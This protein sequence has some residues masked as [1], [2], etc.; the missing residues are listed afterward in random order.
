MIQIDYLPIVLTGIGIMVAIV[1]YTLTLRNA[2]KTR[3]AQLFMS[4]YETMRSQEFREQFNEIIRQEW[5]DFDDFWDKYGQDNNPEAW[6]KWQSVA[7][8]YHG[9]G[10]L[11]KKGLVE[12]SML[13]EL[14][15][16]NVYMAWVTMSPVLKGFIERSS[17]G[18]LRRRSRDEGRLSKMYSAWSGFEY[19]YDTLKKKEAEQL[20]GL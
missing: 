19:L 9:M 20:K 7:M 6:T 10:I 3:Q 11:V 1:Y 12:P 8:F 17:T 5:S 13:D 16:P 15:S 4:L 18:A 14:V 2:N